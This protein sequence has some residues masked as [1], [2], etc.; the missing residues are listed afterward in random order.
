[1]KIKPMFHTKSLKIFD[2]AFSVTQFKQA[3][4]KNK[5][6]NKELKNLLQEKQKLFKKYCMIKSTLAKANYN[7]ARNKYFHALKKQKQEFFTILFKQ[8]NMKQ[9]WNTR[10]INTLLEN[11][12]TK[13]CSL[14]KINNKITNDAQTISNHFNDYFT[15]V[16]S[17][18]VK[19]LPVTSHNHKTYLPPSTT[20]NSL[21]VNPASP[22][23]L[24]NIIY[25]V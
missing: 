10:T 24:K 17:E 8:N 25:Q 20:L 5:W 2:Q 18:L 6:F 11:I 4:T 23:E 19:K 16:T 22:Q 12:K 21:Y 15:N 3:Q 13:I 7:T 9:T 14:F 1:M